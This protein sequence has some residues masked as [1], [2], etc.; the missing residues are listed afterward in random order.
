[1][2]KCQECGADLASQYREAARSQNIDVLFAAAKDAF[3]HPTEESLRSTAIALDDVAHAAAFASG[4]IAA[5][6]AARETVEDI[7]GE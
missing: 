1:M 4:Y 2:P 3:E 6:H 7:T 5:M